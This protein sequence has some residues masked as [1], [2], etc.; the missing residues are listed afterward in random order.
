[1]TAALENADVFG[2]LEEDPMSGCAA[3]P[4]KR[5]DFRLTVKF[6]CQPLAVGETGTVEGSTFEFQMDQSSTTSRWCWNVPSDATGVEFALVSNGTVAPS[7][8]RARRA[9][10]L[11]TIYRLGDKHRRLAMD[12][13]VDFL[14]DLL[15]DGQFQE[16]DSVFREVVVDRLPNSVIVAFLGI[17]RAAADK[18][19]S[20]QRFYERAIRVAASRVGETDAHE[21][22]GVYR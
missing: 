5:A 3:I 19:P 11:E 20:R 6:L 2:D 9:I 16:C 21:L 8:D 14:D 12:H 13:V 22:L 7:G 4:P 1:M 10:A 15:N 18:L 17:T